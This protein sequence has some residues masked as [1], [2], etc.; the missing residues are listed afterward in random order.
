MRENHEVLLRGL[1]LIRRP[2]TVIGLIPEGYSF[3][4]GFA[5]RRLV[6][7][8]RTTHNKFAVI[9]NFISD[10]R[11]AATVTILKFHCAFNDY[12]TAKGTRQN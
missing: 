6:A 12:V 5:D 7:A 1:H 8:T 4:N 2:G 11:Y 3:S 9:V 10:L